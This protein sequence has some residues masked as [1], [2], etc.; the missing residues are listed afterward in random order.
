MEQLLFF[1]FGSVL[2]FFGSESNCFS[3]T[4]I[5][6]HIYKEDNVCANKLA[7]LNHN[8]SSL[9]WWDFLPT[10]L[11]EEFVRDCCGL[12][13]FHFC[14]LCLFCVLFLWLNYTFGPCI[15]T[16]S[17]KWFCLFQIEQNRLKLSCFLQF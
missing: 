5:F 9:S 15:L 17:R 10:S 4:Y 3:L 2:Y 12:L 1:F 16:S 13:N 8:S 7:S 14:L 11:R 6:S